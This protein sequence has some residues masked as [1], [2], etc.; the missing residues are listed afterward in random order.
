MDLNSLLKKEN[1]VC[2]KDHAC[3]IKAVYIYNG[4]TEKL[5]TLAKDYLSILI[6]ADENTYAVAGSSVEKNLATKT[7][8]KVVFSGDSVLIPNEQAIERVENSLGDTDL[9]IGIGSG[10]IQDLCKYV[11][12]VKKI[13]YIIVATAPSMDG[14][15]SDGA[16]MITGGMKV[17]Y[18][19]TVP[20]AIIAEPKV[21]A[22][23][24]FEMIQAGYGD[25]I[26][27]YSALNDWELSKVVNG[28]YFCDFIY[29][30]VLDVVKEVELCASGLVKREE[31]AV[32]KLM[33][34]LVLVGIMMSF[35]GSSRPASGSEHHMAHYY[36][37]TGIINNQ[38]Y[39]PHGIDVGFSTVITAKVREEIL[40]AK[41]SFKRGDDE[42]LRS[43]KLL[44]IY[45]TSAKKCEEL[46]AKIGNYNTDII[47]RYIEKEEE[48]KAVLSKMPSSTEIE[49]LLENVGLK[50]SDYYNLYGEEKIS[51]GII[52]SK[53]LK[54]RYTVFWLYYYFNK[55]FKI[56]YSKIKVIAFDLDGTLTQHRQPLPEKNVLALKEL[57]KKYKLIMVGAGQVQ[58]IFNQMDKFPI[59]IIGNYGMQYGEYDIESGD[60]KMVE[61]KS[62]TVDRESVIERITTLRNKY[63]Y[64]EFKGDTVEFHPS[65]C[66]TF[67]ILGTK[68]VK[69][70]KIKFDPDR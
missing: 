28:E 5:Q 16:A 27:K 44:E 55:R 15:A 12:S 50:L 31:E 26:G 20:L 38:P 43:K 32:K 42:C 18:K 62:V 19:A 48:I 1:C 70:D 65:R 17:T 6:V 7:V 3:N 10:V 8:K 67:A 25:I 63:G 30:T 36:E 53:D 23:A 13:P 40:N 58:R 4:A 37:I 41:W 66:L 57:A 54:D 29:N 69:D 45:K 64:T 61:D 49:K 51:D 24:P 39:L 21:L 9:I 68:A 14:Y 47:S 46:Q 2:G 60:I 11:S 33:E 35:A 56:D 59:D 52:Y 34:A 22:T